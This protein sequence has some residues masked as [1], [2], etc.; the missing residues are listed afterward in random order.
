MNKNTIHTA[1]PQR[2]EYLRK[3]RC[4][5]IKIAVLRISVLVIFIAL[6]EGLTAAG[7][8]DAFIVSSPSR[9]IKTIVNLF[10]EG[11]LFTHI[12]ITLLETVLGFISGTVLGVLMAIWLWCS[13]TARR[14]CEPYLVVLNALPKIALG[15]IIIV[16]IGSGMG[17]I[18]TITLLISLVVT[19]IGV[20]NGFLETDK[21]KIFLL[22][23]FGASKKQIFT[24]VVFPASIPTTIATLKINVGMA[25]VG[26]IVGEFLSSKSGLG[27][28]L[29]YGGQVFKLDLVMAGILIL[30]I[31]AAAMY[32]IVSL[33]EKQ[34]VKML[35]E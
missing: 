2:E 14:V 13:E 15:P 1:S 5:K 29:V 10:N 25:W 22:R 12:G 4:K 7:I 24:T 28:L 34:I 3:R 19:I 23:S 32:Y 20:L 17:A 11:T 21:E 18:I 35:S 26:V 9:C 33:L 8:L 27:Y 6:W 31:L 16:W 30:C